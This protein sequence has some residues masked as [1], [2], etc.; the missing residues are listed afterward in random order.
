MSE[1]LLTD[2]QID[3]WWDIAR[4]GVWRGAVAGRPAE[5]EITA[6]DLRRMA[7]DYDP[8]L[9]EAP[10]TVEHRRS[11]PA[12]GWVADLRVAG[13]VLQARFHRI[14]RKLR[15]WLREGAYRSRSIEMYKP[16]ET[17]GRAYLAA[18]SFLGASPPAVKGLRPEPSA[19]ADG[20]AATVAV[21][22]FACDTPPVTEG[23]QV[24]EQERNIA[25][26][27]VSSLREA[28]NPGGEPGEERRREDELA[29]ERRLRVA[30][31]ARISELESELAGRE[32]T[33][34]LEEFRAA[35]A[36]A[37]EQERIT[38]AELTAYVR[39]GV[40]LD[41][42]G[43]AAILEE[44]NARE[45]LGL[46]VELSSPREGGSADE[47]HRRRTAF[48]GFP[49]DPE[50]DRALRLMAAEPDLSF[51]EAIRRVRETR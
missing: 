6:D 33:H 26:R 15:R 16:F 21:Q 12:L 51:A 23:G 1:E 30:A 36:E 27:A 42:D 40:R 22:A 39:L 45:P 4:P 19:L 46:T 34:R 20:D 44:L 10:V 37:A 8:A 25:A 11:G 13:N 43:R 28:F 47:L 5:I 29:R 48:E 38:P 2:E 14:G 35:V 17:T 3:G 41:D 50:H 49:E 32:R 31:Q 9:Q 18:V 24:K 7:E